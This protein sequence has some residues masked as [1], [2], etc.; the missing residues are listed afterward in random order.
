VEPVERVRW[1]STEAYERPES[2][3]PSVKS[4]V[5][6]AL[7]AEMP[8]ANSDW[9]SIQSSL[10]APGFSA[11]E[12]FASAYGDPAPANTRISWASGLA[13]VLDPRLIEVLANSEPPNTG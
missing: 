1:Q 6:L 2:L 7:Y 3:M 5:D 11:A 9:S 8:T 10:T 4:Q 13:D 12:V